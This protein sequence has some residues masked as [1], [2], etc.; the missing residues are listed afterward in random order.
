MYLNPGGFDEEFYNNGSKM[1]LLT[2]VGYVQG[3]DDQSPNLDV[4]SCLR[5]FLVYSSFY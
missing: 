3:W 5:W 1:G 4:P 2:R